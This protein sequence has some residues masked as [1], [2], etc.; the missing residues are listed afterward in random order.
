VKILAIADDDDLICQRDDAD[1]DVLIALGDLHDDA[2]KRAIAHYRP[3][4]TLAVRGNHDPDVPFPAGVK[5]IHC[6][7]VNFEGIRFAGFE[8]SWRYKPS[9]HHLFEQS[10]VTAIMRGFPKVD[11]FVA[12]NSP[13]GIHERD[14]FVHQGFQGFIAYIDTA[15]PTLMIHGHQHY[16]GVT[17]R[18]ATTIVGVFGER[19]ICLD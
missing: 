10:E 5:D 7:L 15:Q 4:K 6:A 19:L 13:S 8:G 14:E 12:H 17:V 9:G 11:V 1:I 3:R 16:D 18:G 2:I